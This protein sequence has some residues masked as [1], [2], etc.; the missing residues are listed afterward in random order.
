[1]AEEPKPKRPK[2][3]PANTIRVCYNCSKSLQ[4][5]AFSNTQLRKHGKEVSC[6][7][8]VMKGCSSADSN[9]NG[10]FCHGWCQ[11][12]KKKK[13]FPVVER[14]KPQ[15][16]CKA[17]VNRE[18]QA[19]SNLLVCR[20]NGLFCHGCKEQKKK[21]Q[22]PVDEQDTPHP[23]CKACVNR[24]AQAASNLLVCPGSCEE[25]KKKKC[26][27]MEERAKPQPKRKACISRELS[28]PRECSACHENKTQS[29]YSKK[30]WRDLAND[31]RKGLDCFPEAQ[32]FGDQSG[33]S[34]VTRFGIPVLL[35][36]K[37]RAC[38]L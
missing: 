12:Q 27:P 2:P 10:L 36:S 23:K 25:R 11:E 17:C 37:G 21:K 28:A 33:L 19:A 24:E 30:Q 29:E 20:S 4:V 8:C 13:H 1:M 9:S 16:K 38:R 7:A 34:Q 31:R 3:N 15:P 22:F 5:D 14:D 35:I 32:D 18:A 6:K 26:F